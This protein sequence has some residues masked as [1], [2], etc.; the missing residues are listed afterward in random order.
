MVDF[1]NIDPKHHTAKET[2]NVIDIELN[3][4]L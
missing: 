2:M 4:N 3:V 1:M